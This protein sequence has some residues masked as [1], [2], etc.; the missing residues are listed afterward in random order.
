[1]NVNVE[2][3]LASFGYS[4]AVEERTLPRT[5]QPAGAMDELR[6]RLIQNRTRI[7]FDSE[8]ARREFLIAPILMRL[9]DLTQAKIKVEYPFVVNDQLQGTFDYFVQ[10]NQNL[11][12]VEAKN[13]DLERG[14]R[15]LAVELIALDQGIDSSTDK[16]YGVVSIGSAWQFGVLERQRKH[17][18]QDLKLYTIPDDLADLLSILVAIL[19]GE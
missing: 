12:I 13:E 11:L 10:S 16:L 8:A 14:F 17:V 2:E 5:S 15:Q 9:M 7:T 18:A 19:N 3:V 1:M 6:A 4:F